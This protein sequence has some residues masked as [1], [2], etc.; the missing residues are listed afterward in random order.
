MGRVFVLAMAFF[1]AVAAAAPFTGNDTRANAM[2]GTGVA[3]ASA[4]A[5]SQFNPALLNTFNKDLQFGLQLPSLL[6]AIDDGKGFEEAVF[7]LNEFKDTNLIALESEVNGK[8]TTPSLAETV[9]Q[10]R[11]AS[12]FRDGASQQDLEAFNAANLALNAKVSVIQFEMNKFNTATA[13]T[14]TSFA[15]LGE[16]PL[17]FLGA[18]SAV[19]ALPRKGTGLAL[20]LNANTNLG[21]LT[22]LSQADLD[23]VTSIV[24]ATNGFANE[25]Q[26]LTQLSANLSTALVQFNQFDT[27]KPPCS[28]DDIAYQTAFNKLS[29][30]Q[31]ALYAET[32]NEKQ[33]AA[34]CDGKGGFTSSEETPVG[35]TNLAD[36]TSDNGLFIDGELQ[37]SALEALG[38]ESNIQLLGAN[39]IELGVSVARQSKIFNQSIALSV[40]PKLQWLQVIDGRFNFNDG[41]SNAND[42]LVQQV[43]FITTANLDMGM[44]KTWPDIMNGQVQAGMALKDVFPQTFKSRSGE[45]LKIEPKLRVGAAHLTRF[46]T[47]AMDIDLTENKPLGYGSA[48]RQL[49]IGAELDAF[50]W[51]KIRLGYRNN[52]AIKNLHTLTTGFGVNPFGVG[53][54][55]SAWLVPTR[56]PHK[57]FRDAGLAAQLSMS[58]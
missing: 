14:S 17:A 45:T 53:L 50:D 30:A 43:K 27:S 25:A 35:N 18:S 16:K 56:D 42:P 1:T 9:N 52:L 58:W 22:H 38:T 8:G 37:S 13:K 32:T 46:S 26:Q 3:S 24:S 54:D 11:Q 36:Y 5:A 2:G 49:G 6:V 4:I 34:L 41:L 10:V 31:A 23:T 21:V 29:I 33:T 47:L 40:T 20:H 48:S 57:T 15:T 12:D 44:A 28:S 55:V 51:A 19:V 39:L 7:V